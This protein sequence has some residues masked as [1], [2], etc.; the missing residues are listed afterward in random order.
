MFSCRYPATSAPCDKQSSG[1]QSTRCASCCN[2][3]VF[4]FG[5][6]NWIAK[7]MLELLFWVCVVGVTYSYFLYPAILLLAPARSQDRARES[8]PL[9][10]QRVDVVI[11]AR[12]ESGKIAQKIENT[13]ALD[14]AG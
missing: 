2:A 1:A 13:L 11:A 5:L 12:N 3:Y 4:D 9:P 14:R 7:K 10:A 8:V 6:E